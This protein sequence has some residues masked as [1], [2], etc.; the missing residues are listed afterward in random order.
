MGR[1]LVEDVCLVLG[2]MLAKVLGGGDDADVSVLVGNLTL[3]EGRGF[4]RSGSGTGLT[5]S[6]SK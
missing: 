3:P 5:S 2:W 1:K 6:S 4:V